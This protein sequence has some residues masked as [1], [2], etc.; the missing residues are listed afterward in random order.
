MRLDPH[1]R[2]LTIRERARRWDELLRRAVAACGP[3]S[4]TKKPSG[5]LELADQKMEAALR[6]WHD[7]TPACKSDPV[8][9]HIL[10]AAQR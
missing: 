8:L 10:G 5:S 3:V 6:L 1:R 2:G 4:L 9:I 7:A